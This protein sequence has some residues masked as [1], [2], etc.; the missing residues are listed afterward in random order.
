MTAAAH[1]RPPTRRSAR[2]APPYSLLAELATHAPP[3]LVEAILSVSEPVDIVHV[4][5][6]LSS[7]RTRSAVGI[8]SLTSELPASSIDRALL[9]ACRPRWRSEPKLGGLRI[10]ASPKARMRAEAISRYRLWD[11]LG[12]GIDGPPPYEQEISFFAPG[13]SSA[14]SS[15]MSPSAMPFTLGEFEHVAAAL[16]P[17]GGLLRSGEMQL[18]QVTIYSLPPLDSSGGPRVIFAMGQ[19]DSN[20]CGP[21][22]WCSGFERASLWAL[23]PGTPKFEPIIAS[24]DYFDDWGNTPGVVTN[25]LATASDGICKQLCAALGISPT[26]GR[27]G[28]V[29]QLVILASFDAM[30]WNSVEVLHAR[31]GKNGNFFTRNTFQFYEDEED[32]DEDEMSDDRK[33]EDAGEAA[34][35]GESN[36]PSESA[37]QAFPRVNG[38]RPF[39]DDIVLS[40][41]QLLER[42][43][44]LALQGRLG[45][46]RLIDV[47]MQ[48]NRV[49]H[50]HGDK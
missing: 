39:N 3:E 13:D 20:A 26:S 46:P 6:V 16:F 14:P 48:L 35:D 38:A 19:L 4:A 33:W 8:R 25:W 11:V 1:L 49:L 15:V 30:F 36:P 42:L 32:E 47:C 10:A 21:G 7:T 29:I 31:R 37:A 23:I 27:L 24:H 40:K 43:E 34:S 28:Q 9:A 12:I 41:P 50:E 2:L 45:S 44:A 22:C 17:H 18:R 5:E